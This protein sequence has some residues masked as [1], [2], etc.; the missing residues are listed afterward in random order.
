MLKESNSL[1]SHVRE[2]Q[3]SGLALS[4]SLDA[5]QLI[6]RSQV[7]VAI[8][9][10]RG[11]SANLL[12]VGHAQLLEFVTVRNCHDLSECGY[13]KDHFA[14]PNGRPEEGILDPF[15]PG[16]PDLFPGFRTDTG[17]DSVVRPK[18][19]PVFRE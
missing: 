9:Q 4:L 17:N 5:N 15:D 13:A 8:G 18:I 2:I 7:K 11:G 10:G 6:T 3:E 12:E 16:F 19:E 14:C 1:D